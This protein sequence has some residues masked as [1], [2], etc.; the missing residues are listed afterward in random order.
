[1]P[2]P[3]FRY[4]AFISYARADQQEDGRRW[5][6][7]LHYRLENFAVPAALAG[8]RTPAGPIPSSLFP[9]ALPR[10]SE[11]GDGQLTDATRTALEQSRTLIVICSPRAAASTDVAE[12][13]RYFK[14][15]GRD[16]I[17]ALIVAGDPEA[18]TLDEQCYPDPLRHD[19]RKDGSI[20][21]EWRVH[22]I[23]ADARFHGEEGYT[24]P[25]AL[26][27][28]LLEDGTPPVKVRAAIPAYAE[29]LEAAWL[30][31]LGGVLGGAF[32]ELARASSHAPKKSSGVAW[33][34]AVLALAAAGG[35]AWLTSQSKIEA[36]R[37]EA[38]RR[39][40]DNLIA[41]VQRDLG[42]KLRSRDQLLLLAEANER[43]AEHFSLSV[44]QGKDRVATDALADTLADAAE[45][46]AARANFPAAIQFATQAV[47]ARESAIQQ[48]GGAGNLDL[49]LVGDHRRLAQLLLKAG[50]K[51]AGLKEA[52]TARRQITE[53]AARR[54]SPET[55]TAVIATA[56]DHG[57]LLAANAQPDEAR[58][59]FEEGYEAAKELAASEPEKSLH[60]R[61]IARG[62][63]RLGRLLQQKGDFPS[64]L[65][66][67]Q[68]AKKLLTPLAEEHP[69][70]ASLLGE[71]AATSE[72]TGSAL[73]LL[74]KFAEAAAEQQTALELNE[75]L[76]KLE[77]A[78]PAWQYDTVASLRRL[79]D[80]L[81]QAGPE[82]RTEVL[83]L[84]QRG[85][86]LLAQR[87]PDKL[88][89]RA[90]TLRAELE[91][92]KLAALQ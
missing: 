44:L 8:R 81:R 58:L 68:E 2:P 73:S 43:I 6:E 85:M 20:D 49:R 25:A 60:Q 55:L 1:M 92:L 90:S 16:R 75:R 66:R 18:P 39:R 47:Q 80:S 52:E 56:Y 91:Q 54:E 3:D 87:F 86:D 11:A 63:M 14:Q 82:N 12:E 78:N 69:T 42:D 21:R 4:H 31:I 46:Q 53:I 79:A 57:D 84:V 27:S 83:T 59:A 22:P 41:W 50:K 72:W 29:K 76:A 35:M 88:D 32:P 45:I 24:S 30:K 23:S 9:V 5:A 15:L 26:E 37:T 33:I 13:V 89:A 51:A 65:A 10:R 61:E 62:E 17:L 70:D 28:A 19:V 64:A 38:A 40:A 71:L 7:W 77:P 34:I 48:G 36:E 67:F 74:R